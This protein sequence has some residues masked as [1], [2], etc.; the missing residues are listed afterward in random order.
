MSLVC[1]RLIAQ[2]LWY[3]IIIII[4][5]LC[6]FLQ[7]NQVARS[8]PP[9]SS[10]YQF[11]ESV[12]P[13]WF[14]HISDTHISP[15]HPENGERLTK[16]LSWYRDVIKPDSVIITGD[17][18][19]QVQSE[20]LLPE[21]GPDASHW[22]EYRRIINESNITVIEVLGNHDQWGVLSETSPKNYCLEFSTVGKGSDFHSMEIQRTGVRLVTF[23]PFTFPSAGGLTGFWPVVSQEM[24]TRLENVL[25]NDLSKQ[26]I[27]ISHFPSEIFCQDRLP[28]K[29]VFYLSS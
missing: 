28:Q 23:Q 16:I 20:K 3:V 25:K 24:L 14:G 12:N 5:V 7:S 19:D 1:A 9:D 21:D 29:V 15:I 26:T 11:S 13:V 27:L 10:R 4:F 2:Y 18:T 6:A 22:I 8:F 17:L